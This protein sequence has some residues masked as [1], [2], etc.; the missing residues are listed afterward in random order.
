[1]RGVLRV[2]GVYNTSYLKP[3]RPPTSVRD[4]ANPK[5]A[6]KLA[7]A[8]GETAFRPITPI[9][10]SCGTAAALTW[11]TAVKDPNRTASSERGRGLSHF[12][13]VLRSV[14]LGGR[15]WRR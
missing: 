6:G 13:S 3:S 7:L 8:P 1:M 2:T 12:C 5:W 10:D 14:P 4:L 11:L 9:A 15:P